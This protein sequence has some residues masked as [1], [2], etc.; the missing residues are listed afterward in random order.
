MAVKHKKSRSECCKKGWATRRKRAKERSERAKRGWETRRE[1][2][3]RAARAAEKRAT[4]ARKGH[5]TRKAKPLPPPRF[6][7]IV[8]Q[9]AYVRVEPILEVKRAPEI[10]T[11]DDID[12]MVADFARRRIHP[13][14]WARDLAN[15]YDLEI[16]PLYK[17]YFDITSPP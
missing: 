2:E 1:N 8:R 15:Y 11:S 5:K 4:R 9:Q 16:G 10:L 6:I 7:P 17:A 13:D 12:A 14:A 3:A